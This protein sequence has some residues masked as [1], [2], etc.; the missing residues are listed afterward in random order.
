VGNDEVT[1]FVNNGNQIMEV[2]QT[3][4]VTQGYIFS[5]ADLAVN[6]LNQVLCK[7]QND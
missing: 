3:A 5:E 7:N 1:R 4:L 6:P 2:N